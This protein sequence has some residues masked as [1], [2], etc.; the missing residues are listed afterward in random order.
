ML[1]TVPESFSP[2]HCGGPCLNNV[3]FPALFPFPFLCLRL[4]HRYIVRAN[5]KQ[6]VF[7]GKQQRDGVAILAFIVAGLFGPVG[8]EDSGGAFAAEHAAEA[9]SAD[10]G[11]YEGDCDDDAA[12]VSKN[13]VFD[14]DAYHN[15]WGDTPVHVAVTSMFAEYAVLYARIAGRTISAVPPPMTLT[16]G[17]DI[18]K[19]A[20]NFVNKFVTPILGHIASVKVHKLLCHV[21]DAIKW[22]GNLQNGNTAANESGHKADKSF[23]ARTNKDSRTFT[24]QIVRHA[25]GARGILARHAADDKAAVAEWQTQLAQRAAARGSAA[26]A[27]QHDDATAT[28]AAAAVDGR[29]VAVGGGAAVGRREAAAGGGAAAVRGAVAVGALTEAERTRRRKR[30]LYNVSSV[31]VS[32]LA[33]RPD[34]ANVGALLGMAAHRQVRVTTR[35]PIQARFECG[36]RIQQHLR[37]AEDFLG[38]P[39]YDSVLYHPGGDSSRLCVG[40]LRTI[41]RGPKGDAVVLV[42][43]ESVSAE[44]LC[45][46]VA[47]GCVRLKWRIADNASD[48]TLRLVPVAHVR[49]LAVVVPDFSDLAGRRGVDAD[50]PA[51]DSPLQDRLDMRYFLNVF[52]PWDVK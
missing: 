36:T 8:D 46:F 39:W 51:M 30:R 15:E 23:Y 6:A 44:P 16:E 49:R 14:W 11:G 52:F 3:V 29:R 13:F 5:E 17:L 45:P 31:S 10:A 33:R 27:A 25:H 20:N 19:Q 38:A 37:A 47:R 34:L 21:A 40:E 43:M 32:D 12:K 50:L 4:L 26:P 41:V 1:S 48:V 22:H 2:L 7:T 18:A 28:T 24:R 9:A 35:T 42:P